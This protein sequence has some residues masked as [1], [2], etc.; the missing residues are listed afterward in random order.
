MHDKIRQAIE[1]A[2]RDGQ[3]MAMFHYQVLANAA[4]VRSADPG[5]FC[6]AVGVPA[7]YATE[8]RKM[9]GLA[10]LMQERGVRLA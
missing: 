9:L 2:S 1:S 5:E 3:K 6:R 8:F 4:E 7:S 10:R